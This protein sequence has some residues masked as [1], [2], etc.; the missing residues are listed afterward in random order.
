[1]SAGADT[2]AAAS[3]ADLFFTAPEAD[4]ARANDLRKRYR[5]W[6]SSTGGPATAD[7]LD[8]NHDAL[9]RANRSSAG[10]R[11]VK[12]YGGCLNSISPVGCP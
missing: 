3:L 7:V 8:L 1:M 10:M 6:R 5:E 11:R 2:E 9:A 4:K 12:T